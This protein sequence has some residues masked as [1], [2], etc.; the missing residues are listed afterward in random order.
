MTVDIEMGMILLFGSCLSNPILYM[1]ALQK[2]VEC[3]EEDSV[4][5]GCGFNIYTTF[6]SYIRF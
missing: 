1:L 4:I 2:V 6:F 3:W 5:L